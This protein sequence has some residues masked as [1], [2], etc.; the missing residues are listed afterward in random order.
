[1][2]IANP[3]FDVTFKYLME[4]IEIAKKI[5]SAIINEEIVELEARPQ[6]QTNNSQS[7][8]L[9]VYR[10][11]FKA[12]I[13]TKEGT[14]KKVLIELQKSKKAFDVLRFRYYLGGN[15]GQTDLVNGVKVILPIIPIYIL[16]F[17]LTIDKPLLKIG[18]VYQD[19]STGQEIAGKDDFIE[20]LSHDCFIIQI[21]L[22]SKTVQSKVERLLSVFNQHW[23]FDH[24]AEW[25]M[26]YPKEEEIKNHDPDLVKILKRL[27]AAAESEGF[28]E[29]IRAE[30]ELDEFIA[31]KLREGESSFS[32][33]RNR[34]EAYKKG[35]GGN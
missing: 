10:M 6:E 15:Y 4:D 32:T 5:I 23:V 16:G 31:D 24:N 33:E 21:P 34:A 25:V 18:R 12:V 14:L 7:H 26:R 1:M 35:Q 13:K 3:I 8:F 22:L 19:I 17:K 9:T 29:R 28:K 2:F 20:Q 30:R 11:D 27:E